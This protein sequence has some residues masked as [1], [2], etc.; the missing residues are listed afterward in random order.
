MAEK[1]V[2]QEPWRGDHHRANPDNDEQLDEINIIFGGSLSIASKTQGKKLER[3]INLAQR[4]EPERRMKR[5]D[6]YILFGPEDHPKI[7]LSNR[8][9]PFVIKLPIGRHK[10]AK[11][12]IDNG[13]FLNLIMWKTFIEM[14]LNPSDL[15][16][17]H[18]MFHDVIPGQTSTPI[19]RINLEVSCRSGDN[20]CRETLTFEGSSFDIGY[21]CILGRPFLLKFMAIIYTA[22]AT[23]KMSES[24]GV[25][26]IKV[27]QLDALACENTSLSHVGQFGDKAAPDQAA[28]AVKTQ[29]DS[30]PIKTSASKPPTSSTL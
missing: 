11:S 2:A 12:L 28:K 19:G 3:E 20:K 17:I 27:E 23:M 6:T 18:D 7:E 29:G 26:T 25:I 9:L 16:P 21:N 15:T 30:A 4:I 22:Y 5:S 14:G 10:V 8:N 13:A 24:K 1:P